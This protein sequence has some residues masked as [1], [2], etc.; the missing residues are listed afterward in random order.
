MYHIR[1]VW[2]V[3]SGQAR[4]AAE[5]VKEIANEY[6]TA[7]Q[8]SKSMIYFNGGTLPSPKDE[9]NRVYMQWTADIIDSP[10]RKGNQIPKSEAYSKLNE[11]V[12]KSDGPGSWVEFWEGID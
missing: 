1:R 8:R 4:K 2:K 9:L 3:Q 7:G 5:L 11:L 6:S 10:Y 12:D